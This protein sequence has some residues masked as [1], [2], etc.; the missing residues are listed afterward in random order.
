MNCSNKRTLPE[1]VPTGFIVWRP[2]V[3]R[4]GTV[5]RQAYEICMLCSCATDCAPAMS[6]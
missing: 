1:N 4:R 6:G 5:D 2:L 3:L